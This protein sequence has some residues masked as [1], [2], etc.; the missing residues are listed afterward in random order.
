MAK[1]GEQYFLVSGS[2][3]EQ[4]SGA[5]DFNT[6]ALELPNKNFYNIRRK[7]T[8]QLDHQRLILSFQMMQQIGLFT[9]ANN[10]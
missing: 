8:P 5:S 9:K 3:I 7:H 2:L 10:L 1:T 4:Y 6:D